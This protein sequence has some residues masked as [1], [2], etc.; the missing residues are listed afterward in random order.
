MRRLFWTMIVAAG[1]ADAQDS[2][3]V[4]QKMIEVKYVDA[5]S[6]AHLL[7]AFGV[8]PSANANLHVIALRGTAESLAAAEDMVKKLDVPPRN[9]ELTVYMVFGSPQ[10]KPTDEVPQELASTIKQLR[11]LFPYKGYR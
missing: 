2:T 1:L 10:V 9:V 3:K 7:S 5:N 6:V 11:G 4:V 8:N